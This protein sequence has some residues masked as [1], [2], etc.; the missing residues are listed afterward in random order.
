MDVMATTEGESA[1]AEEPPSPVAP[2]EPTDGLEVEVEPATAADSGP[3]VGS[4]H[5]DAVEAVEA[6]KHRSLPDGAESAAPNGLHEDA[7]AAR[8]QARHRGRA[9]R[10][11]VT[12]MMSGAV[13]GAVE[14]VEASE[15]GDADELACGSDSPAM[16]EDKAAARI[17]AMQRGKW[18]GKS[19]R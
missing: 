4:E 1:V 3:E 6:S 2:S 15:A 12:E 5:V 18:F 7:A 14:A 10:R 16:D 8:I 19:S 17:Q 9:G 11:K 13:V